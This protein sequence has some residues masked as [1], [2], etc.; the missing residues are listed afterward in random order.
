MDRTDNDFVY[1]GADNLEVMLKAIKYNKFLTDQVLAYRTGT[2]PVLDFGAG[3]GTFSEM[4]RERGCDVD[5]VEIDATEQGIL[6]RKGFRVFPSTTG[7]ADARYDY[8]FSLNVFEHIE[9]D[10]AA[11][12]DCARVLRPGGKI[13]VYVPA[14]Q[15]L[16]GAMD[17]KVAHFRRYTRGGL[18]ALAEAGGLTV[19]RS[20]YVDIAG[21][22]ATIAYNVLSR[23]SGDIN[24]TTIAFYDR[25]VFPVSRSLDAVSSR[26]VGKNAFMVAHKP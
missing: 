24:E 18:H 17:R 10:L 1:S 13:Y 15:A 11:M 21:Y 23:S 14:F 5:C 26:F 9:N 16:F 12:K 25:Y 2:G 19:E 20:G 7:I 6:R 8:A 4:V 3:I 22:F